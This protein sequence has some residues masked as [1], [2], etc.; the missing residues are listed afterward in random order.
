MSHIEPESL[1]ALAVP[2]DR[3][4]DQVA[5]EKALARAAEAAELEKAL[6]SI[7]NVATGHAQQI[8]LGALRA[9]DWSSR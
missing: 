8:A 1:R 7:S 2:V 5:L 9:F 3:M 6:I 4:D